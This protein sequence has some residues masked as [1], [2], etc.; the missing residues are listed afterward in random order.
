MVGLKAH[1]PKGFL[2]WLRFSKGYRFQKYAHL[3]YRSQKFI[4]TEVWLHGASRKGLEEQIQ[5]P[6]SVLKFHSLSLRNHGK[7]SEI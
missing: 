2:I 3:P 7:T 6:K 4:A 1:L 5:E